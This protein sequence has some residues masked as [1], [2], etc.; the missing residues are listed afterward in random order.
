MKRGKLFY[1]ITFVIGLILLF[2]QLPLILKTIIDF[3]IP[4]GIVLSVGFIS[5]LI[6]YKNYSDLYGYENHVGVYSYRGKQRYL[7]P[8]MHFSV[9]YGGIIIFL[10][11]AS[12]YYLS[13]KFETKT[14]YD[15]LDKGSYN[16]KDSSGK[17]PYFVVN[18]KGKSK[19][20][21]FT[22]RDF[23]DL[24]E[25]KKIEITTKKGFFNYDILIDKKIVKTLGN[26][27]YN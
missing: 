15:I 6:D 14:Q 10:F 4:I 25:S 20:F 16:V 19:E 18:Y 23:E 13:N 5:C 2:V 21:V 11:F 24:D 27:G 12:N 7:N 8:F 3:Y 1:E 26:N 22:E 17:K 9:S